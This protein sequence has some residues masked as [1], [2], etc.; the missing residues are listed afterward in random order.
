MSADLGG[1]EY[2]RRE[3]NRFTWNTLNQSRY[4]LQRFLYR[5]QEYKQVFDMVMRSYQ[6]L[7]E[8]FEYLEELWI[9][10]HEAIYGQKLSGRFFFDRVWKDLFLERILDSRHLK[11]FL[12]DVSDQEAN[13]L[14]Q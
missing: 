10:L 14:R 11:H 4:K 3:G 8:S 9:Y 6:Q 1:Y 2:I 13:L 7:N 12:N 5:Q